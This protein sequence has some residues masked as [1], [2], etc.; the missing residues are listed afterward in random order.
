M[1]ANKFS[2]YIQANHIQGMDGTPIHLSLLEPERY[3]NFKLKVAIIGGD[4][5][6][7]E[8]NKRLISNSDLEIYNVYGPTECTVDV[9]NYHCTVDD[10]INVPIGKPIANTQIYIM[11]GN[12]LCGIG[13]PGEI[14]IGGICLSNGYLNLN[15]LTKEKFVQNTLDKQIPPI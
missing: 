7:L 3:E 15:D 10:E 5:I 1:D 2:E 11:D 6:N 8:N 9:T 13:V 4:V 12:N 14:Y